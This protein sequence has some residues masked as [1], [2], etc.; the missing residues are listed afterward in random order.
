MEENGL[1]NN[2]TDRVKALMGDEWCPYPSDLM[3]KVVMIVS[4]K[5][6]TELI[7]ERRTYLFP[8]FLRGDPMYEKLNKIWQARN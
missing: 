8:Q 7:K 1:P 6:A 3:M 4:D 2:F 5:A